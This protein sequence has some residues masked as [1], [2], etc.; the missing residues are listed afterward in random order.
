MKEATSNQRGTRVPTSNKPLRLVQSWLSPLMVTSG[1]DNGSSHSNS[2]TGNEPSSTSPPY[3]SD[4]PSVSGSPVVP[5]IN[6]VSTNYMNVTENINGVMGPSESRKTAIGNRGGHPSY[7]STDGG[8]APLAGFASAIMDKRGHATRR[9]PSIRVHAPSRS[10]NHL[11]KI[12]NDSCGQRD[13]A[14]N[15]NHPYG[16]GPCRNTVTRR[17]AALPVASSSTSSSTSLPQRAAYGS[18]TQYGSGRGPD[19]ISSYNSPR[20]GKQSHRE[21]TAHRPRAGQLHRTPSARSPLKSPSPALRRQSFSMSSFSSPPVVPVPTKTS[22]RTRTPRGNTSSDLQVVTGGGVLSR[23]E[24]NGNT[25][26]TLNYVS[27][28]LD[29]TPEPASEHNPSS[30]ALPVVRDNSRLTR[31]EE[32][33]NDP[34]G[35]IEKTNTVGQRRNASLDEGNRS[36]QGASGY[37]AYWAQ[38]RQTS[39]NIVQPNVS[40]REQPHNPS[41]GND[42][43]SPHVHNADESREKPQKYLPEVPQAESPSAG[44]TV[45]GGRTPDSPPFASPSLPNGNH[46]AF[47][48]SNLATPGW[49]AGPGVGRNWSPARNP[50]VGLG[51]GIPV[52]VATRQALHKLIPISQAECRVYI[53]VAQIDSRNQTFGQIESESSRS[54]K[55][56]YEDLSYRLVTFGRAGVGKSVI[57]REIPPKAVRKN[58]QGSLR[59][60][61]NTIPGFSDNGSSSHAL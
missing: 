21:G 50:D 47:S 28:L 29:H 34:K 36:R 54:E 6:D 23:E 57:A 20:P 45:S 15:P 7:P 26:V 35:S 8:K 27:P 44:P 4:D 40:R 32:S 56:Q 52:A 2:S 51:L 31:N 5:P 13:A 49:T 17:D 60:I 25:T 39:P 42:S 55:N 22:E 16:G 30:K 48:S 33:D 10:V 11:G 38:H 61:S 46:R 58:I 59:R 19:Q 1:E 3:G 53:G 37:D 24:N 18:E 9:C 12:T 41:H 14:N 43:R